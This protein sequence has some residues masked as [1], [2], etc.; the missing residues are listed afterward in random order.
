VYTTTPSSPVAS[1]GTG[2]LSNSTNAGSARGH[3]KW[4]P[5][6][7]ASVTLPLVWPLVGPTDSAKSGDVLI[8]IQE[9]Q[10]ITVNIG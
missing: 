8:V 6:S 5:G 3:P 7:F 1:M 9:L 4:L 2:N 10:A